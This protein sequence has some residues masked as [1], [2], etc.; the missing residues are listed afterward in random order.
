MR[1]VILDTNFILSCV[2]EKIDFFEEIRFLGMKIIIPKQVINEIKRISNK[3]AI[4][5]NAL[6]SLKIIEKNKFE[7]I[8]LKENYVDK[9]LI[10]FLKK[11]PD[12]IIASLDK[13]LTN[14]IKN[15]KLI[16]RNKKK[17]VL[18]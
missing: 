14:K 1:K 8:D 16:I 2:K 10:K 9:A 18:E 13:E 4:K 5:D 17:L 11:N 12:I 6:L 3:K 7:S 15:R